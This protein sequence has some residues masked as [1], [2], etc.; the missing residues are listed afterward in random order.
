MFEMQRIKNHVFIHQLEKTISH[1]SP[2]RKRK[3]FLI[4]QCIS[5]QICLQIC[6][7]KV[8]KIVSYHSNILGFFASNHTL[9]RIN[10]ISNIL[11]WLVI[12]SL[13]EDISQSIVHIKKTPFTM[14]IEGSR[15]LDID[16]IDHQKLRVARLISVVDVLCCRWLRG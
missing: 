8:D 12:S 14:K 6:T 13:Q 16:G 11:G 2:I 7:K 10:S 4:P 5:S 3:E 9:L 1:Y 15:Y